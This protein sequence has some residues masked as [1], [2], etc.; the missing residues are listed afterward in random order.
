MNSTLIGRKHATLY[1]ATL[2]L[3]ILILTPLRHNSKETLDA[4]I[5]NF[6]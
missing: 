2:I 5:S 3:H 6:T 1:I 4:L